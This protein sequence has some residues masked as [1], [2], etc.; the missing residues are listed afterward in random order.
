[1]RDKTEELEYQRKLLEALK[2][3]INYWA[4]V[5]EE[6]KNDSNFVKIAVSQDFRLF[7]IISDEIA[8]NKDI[9]TLA[10]NSATSYVK[11]MES[12]FSKYLPKEQADVEINKLNLDI[13]EP[14]NDR[15]I[16]A[17]KHIEKGKSK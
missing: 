5:P 12:L 15:I 13:F 4:M 10:K 9:Q 1:M 14:I 6:Y 16:E 11:E 7:Q 17:E 8:L 2:K 3:N